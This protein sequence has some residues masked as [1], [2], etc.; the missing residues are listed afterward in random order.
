[1]ARPPVCRDGYNPKIP[2]R[3]RARW[4]STA[5]VGVLAVASLL[6]QSPPAPVIIEAPANASFY[7]LTPQFAIS[8]D[9]SQLVVVA[10]PKGGSAMLWITPTTSAAPPR[11]LA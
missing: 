6:A 3:H 5:T 8:P 1:M 10:S 2:M 11:L 7:G 4:C 9:G